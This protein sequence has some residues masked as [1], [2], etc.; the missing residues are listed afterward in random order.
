MPV[1][2]VVGASRGLGLEFAKQYADD[3]WSVLATHRAPADADRLRAIGAQPIALDVLDPH[4]PAALAAALA[5]AGA[6]PEHGNEATHAAG[7]QAAAAHA[8][9]G[10]LDLAIVNAGIH[11]PR[12]IGVFDPPSASDFDLVMHTNVHAPMRLLPVLAPLLERAS[13]TL[14]LVSSSMG[15]VSAAGDGHGF[16]YRVSKAA[17]NMV[18]KVAHVEFAPSGIRVVAL[19]PGWVRTDMG[20]PNAA[21]DAP[22]SIAGMRRVIADRAAYPGGGF[23]D[24]RGESLAW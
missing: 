16:L 10:A 11:G 24:F 15:S 22:R 1:A 2:L 17:L 20:G 23:Y 14:V 12:K 13:G 19:N 6:T 8:I 3:G 18:A 7:G 9:V 5:Q 21:V 4:A